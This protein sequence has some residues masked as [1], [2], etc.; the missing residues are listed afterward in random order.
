MN[1]T[2]QK[3]KVNRINAL[4][5][6]TK[7]WLRSQKRYLLHEEHAMLQGLCDVTGLSINEI[8]IL[9]GNSMNAWSLQAWMLGLIAAGVL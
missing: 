4:S 8:K 9:S 1:T 6:G 3:P 7:V 5:K 2:W